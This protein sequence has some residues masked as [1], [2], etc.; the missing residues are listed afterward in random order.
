MNTATSIT[1]FIY[2][3]VDGLVVN[4]KP[5]SISVP[6]TTSLIGALQVQPGTAA[7]TEIDLPML[8]INQDATYIQIQNETGQELNMAWGGNWEFH[9]A[10]G[11]I[12]VRSNPAPVLAGS[13]T[14]WRFLLTQTQVALGAI[15]FHVLG[16]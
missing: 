16:S 5:I 4:P 8:G 3:D 2:T 1:R 12:F 7:G 13:I 11:G 9:L 14:A 6:Y 15:I 10:P